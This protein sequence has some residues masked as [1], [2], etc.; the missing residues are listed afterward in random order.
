MS[1]W[2][3]WWRDHIYFRILKAS[4]KNHSTSGIDI[5]H[6]CRKHFDL[7]TQPSQNYNFFRFTFC[8]YAM[9]EEHLDRNRSEFLLFHYH[10]FKLLNGFDITIQILL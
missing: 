8:Y 9:A 10:V 4:A 6:L 1:K 5:Y 2:C 7:R 3:I